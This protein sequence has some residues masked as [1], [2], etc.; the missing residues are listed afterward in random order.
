MIRYERR[1][2]N[3]LVC[4]LFIIEILIQGCS[5]SV[6]QSRKD[7]VCFQDNCIDV[8]VVQ[9]MRKLRKGMQ[10]REKL[11]SDS[12]MLFIFPKSQRHSFWMKDTLIPLDIIWMD[13]TRKIVHIFHQVLP[14][15]TD[16]CPMHT[17][18]H[19]ALYVLEVNVGF[20][21]TWGIQ[22]GDRAEFRLSS[23]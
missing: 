19:P 11:A 9:K 1:T 15:K 8:E 4:F 18:D 2:M 13:Q 17:P 12:G 7:Q 23:H 5:L 20:A 3:K 22:I 21:A 6:T 16:P 10:F 14:C